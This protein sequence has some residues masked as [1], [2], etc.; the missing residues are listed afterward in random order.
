MQITA[1]T[2][3][4]NFS[5]TCMNAHCIA[6]NNMYNCRHLNS[7]FK[8]LKEGKTWERGKHNVKDGWLELKQ[9]CSICYYYYYEMS[10]LVKLLSIF[11]VVAMRMTLFVIN[12]IIII[13][14]IILFFFCTY[15]AIIIIETQPLLISSVAVIVAVVILFTYVRMSVPD[16]PN[17]SYD[18]NNQSLV[19]FQPSNCIQI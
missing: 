9:Y 19:N 7:K 13:I 1:K 6:W 5:S 16:Q 8:Y 15:Y 10:K 12:Y 11:S 2:K 3:V 14:Y 17:K 4:L 18:L